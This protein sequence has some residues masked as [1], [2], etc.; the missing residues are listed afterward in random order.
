M[1]APHPAAQSRDVLIL[2]TSTGGGHDSVAVAL[3]EALRETDPDATVQILDP[4]A[5]GGP[6]SFLSP[7][8]WY[9]AI[10]AHAPWLWGVCY[11]ATNNRWA[12]RLGAAIVA[13]LW[14]RRLRA[15]VAAR[16]PGSVVAVHPLCVRLAATILRTLPEALP[17]HCVVTDLVTIHQYWACAS[18]DRFYVATPEAR[19]ALIRAGI[20]RERIDLTGLPLRAPFTRVPAAPIGDGPPRVL[21]LGGGCASRRIA[22]VTRALVAS[23]HPLQLVV[24]CGRNARLQR[25]LARTVGAD[26]T[27]LGWCDDIGAL[28]RWSSIVIARGG[29]T[30]LLE[31]LSQARP[32]VIYQALPGQEA[33]NITFVARTGASCYMPDLAT[34]VRAVVTCRPPYPADNLVQA[35]WLGGAARRV[36]QRL[37]QGNTAEQ[38]RRSE[39]VPGNVLPL[40]ASLPSFST[41]PG[42]RGHHTFAGDDAAGA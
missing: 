17:L 16:R 39:L 31:V 6:G 22:R 18:V 35:R 25:R 37:L 19:D 24:V 3:R 28:V 12:I 29:P 23:P 10:V 5:S 8:R 33:G 27:V 32:V 21:V 36:A 11:H 30:T 15:T 40:P 4:F 1:S 7:G 26:A 42:V 41:A 9:D 13:L 34:L 2:T 38:A 14:A 20:P